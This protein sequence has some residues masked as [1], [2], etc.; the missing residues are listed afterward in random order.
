M[1][2][3]KAEYEQRFEEAERAAKKRKREITQAEKRI[4]E[5]DRIFKRIYED[6]ISGTISHGIQKGFL[7]YNFILL[8]W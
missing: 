7:H 5:L 1:S 2:F 3:Q 6:D 8:S 4:T